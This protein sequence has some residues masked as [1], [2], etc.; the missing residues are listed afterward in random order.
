MRRT[1]RQYGTASLR[2]ECA[3]N[4]MVALIGRG[5]KTTPREI[6][7]TAYHI[8]DQMMRQCKYWAVEAMGDPK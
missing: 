5:E 2:D 1:Q 7:T 6:A 4:A 8:A 3:V